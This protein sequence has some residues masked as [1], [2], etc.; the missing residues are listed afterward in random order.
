MTKPRLIKK[1]LFLLWM[2]VCAAYLNACATS[3]TSVGST[4]QN[5]ES[6]S[7]QTETAVNTP[8]DTSSNNE[9]TREPII[10][11]A[12][13]NFINFSAAVSQ[14]LNTQPGDINLD[15]EEAQL[16]EFIA[17]VMGD[18]LNLNYVI[19]PNIVGS[20]TLHTSTPVDQN[21]LLGLVEVILALN[22]AM[23]VQNNNFYR[24]IPST[25][26]SAG[27]ISPRLGGDLTI[28]GFGVRIFPLQFIAA[29][30]MKELLDPIVADTSAVTT[31]QP[32]N[33]IIASG[34]STELQTIEE[35][36]AIFDVDWLR[37]RSLALIPLSNVDPLT[38][39]A[40]LNAILSS[41]N[42]P[43]LQ[44]LVRLVP[45]ERLSSILV[46]SATSSAL[47]EVETWVRR[48]D[49]PS[50]SAG[51]KIYVYTVQNGK[52]LELADILQ[53]IFQDSG[54]SGNSDTGLA[55][56]NGDTTLAPGLT[57]AQI[58]DDINTSPG[59]GN[60]TGLSFS[61]NSD[62][63]IIGDD[64]RNALV[65]LASPQDYSMIE[66]AIR[67]LDIVPLQVLIEASIIEVTLRDELSYGVEWFFQNGINSG[68]FDG[69]GTLDLGSPGITALAPGFSYTILDSAAQVRV[70]LNALATVSEVSVLSSPSLMVLDNQT[71][72]INVGDEIPVPTRQ[73]ISNIDPTS[74]TVNEISFRQTGIT[75]TVTPRVNAS[76]LVTMDIIQEVATAATTTTSSLDAP[77]IQNR[78]IESVVA[79]NSGETIMLGGLMLEQQAVSESGLPFLSRIPIL[80]NLF[81]QNTNED[82]R[83]E[84]LV[85][86]TPRVI[87]NQD[88]A[89][90][91]TEEY[92]SR[93]TNLPP[94]PFE[95]SQ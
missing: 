68:E 73:S 94:L 65:I 93:L 22:D 3:Q 63:K 90:S 31:D 21:S 74:P 86:I 78:R 52:A 48:L 92:R 66:A 16:N 26:F 43:A 33:L 56:R 87:R 1:T 88:D 2:F 10:E 85:L 5:P 91:I 47:R 61:N 11:E 41:G 19:D 83:T 54:Q 67:Q 42:E 9:N 8:I 62:I 12:S 59:G 37:G 51:R 58:G 6:D 39:E 40:E 81:S 17:L 38:L 28:A 70:A 53:S 44:G 36:I 13:G 27:S 29:E 7:S 50:E 76:G 14:T 77:T 95:P 72:T 46:V 57:P 4:S 30:E 23:L 75:L 25:D 55:S 71:A 15:F 80:G 69:F 34:T 60:S 35:T 18:L 45:I 64:V 20:V 84:L 82:S 89:R 32:R 79:I 24:I 49:Q